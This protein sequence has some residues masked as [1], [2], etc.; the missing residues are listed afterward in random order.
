MVRAKEMFEFSSTS[1]LP[2]RRMGLKSLSVLI[3]CGP[4]I[5]SYS[6][7]IKTLPFIS[8]VNEKLPGKTPWVYNLGPSIYY[9]KKEIYLVYDVSRS[10]Y[11]TQQLNTWKNA[12]WL[13]A[14]LS[15]ALMTTTI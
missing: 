11:R 9:W 14:F 2:P 15:T 6:K 10:R 3:K 5:N 8:V 1:R 13:N 7:S 12:T 4:K